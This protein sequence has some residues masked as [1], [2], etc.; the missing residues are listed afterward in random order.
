MPAPT[1]GKSAT[2]SMPWSRRWTAIGP[3]GPIGSCGTGRQRPD[4]C[5]RR[6]RLGF[7]LRAGDFILNVV[8]L[9]SNSHGTGRLDA[10][11]IGIMSGARDTILLW[12]PHNP[13]VGYSRRSWL[14][15]P[16]SPVPMAM[17]DFRRPSIAIGTTMCRCSMAGGEPAGF[18]AAWSP[19]A[20]SPAGSGS[21][22]IGACPVLHRAGPARR[23]GA[24][25]SHRPGISFRGEATIDRPRLRDRRA[26]RSGRFDAPSHLS[27]GWSVAQRR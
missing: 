17:S 3:P 6:S 13:I 5:G 26:G 15:T 1:I 19:S 14:T 18:L 2:G 20:S 27:A 9:S 12:I 7:A 24:R 10:R 21:R 4:R 11:A 23:G 8:A 25:G 16:G 22:T